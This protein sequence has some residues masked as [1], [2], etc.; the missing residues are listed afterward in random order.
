MK[1]ITVTLEDAITVNGKEVAELTIRKPTVKDLKLSNAAGKTELDRSL[2]LIGDLAGLTPTDLD[3]LSL[4]DL[5]KINE[6]MAKANFIPSAPTQ[7][8]S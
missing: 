5:S 2:A 6:E 3:G 8:S 7:P 4:T 1:T